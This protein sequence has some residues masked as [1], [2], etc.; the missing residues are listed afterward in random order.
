MQELPAVLKQ[1]AAACPSEQADSATRLFLKAW[2]AND[3][4][5]AVP[6]AAARERLLAVLRNAEP[7]RVHMDVLSYNAVELTRNL[8]APKTRERQQL[9]EAYDASL[10]GLANDSTLSR[11]DRL[12]ALIARTQLARID[13]PKG[14]APSVP[15]ALLTDV[16]EQVARIDLETTDGYE[17][18]AVITTAADLLEEAGVPN[19]SDALLK[20]NLARSSSP[21]YLMLG[22]AA[23]AKK[24]GDKAEALRWYEEAYGKSEGP[25]TRLQW[26]AT[27]VTALIDLAPQDEARIERAVQQVFNEAAAQPNVFYERS[28][29]SLKRVGDKLLGWQPKHAAVVKRLRVQLDGVCRQLPADD[30]QRAVCDGLLKPAAAQRSG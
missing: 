3:G 7:S 6:D 17:R 9:L 23:N 4:K 11:A 19:E 2:A 20:A 29:R 21:Y 26:G 12:T 22:L 14:A 30:G 5:A 16:R 18:Q 28:A 27:Y 25:S 8:S 15:P 10:A 13:Q 24:R 1:L